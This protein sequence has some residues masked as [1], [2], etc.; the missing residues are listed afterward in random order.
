MA[1]CGSAVGP[2]ALMRHRHI[3]WNLAG[4]GLPLLVAL[5]AV[6]RLLELLGAQRFGLLALAWGLIGYASA[7]DLGIG[8]ATTQAVAAMRG[9]RADSGI[10][11]VVHSALR[12]TICSGAVAML[13]IA[14]AALAGVQSSIEAAGV[15]A[16]EMQRSLLLLAFALPLQAIA[17]TYRGVNEAFLNFAG[18]NLLRMLLG[19]AN[20]AAPWLIA[21]WTVELHWLVAT[22][23]LSRALA[24]VFYRSQARQ[25]LRREGHGAGRYRRDVAR[26]L[27]GFGAGFTVS[28]IVG[29]L[30][31]QSD[32]FFVGALLGAAAVTTYVIPY[33]VVVQALIGVG[34]VA[35]VIFPVVSSLLRADPPAAAALFRLWRTRVTV[36]MTLLMAGLAA[37]LPA[38]LGW[39]LHA[40]PS[41]D[42]IAIGRILCV[43]VVF[44]SV[45][46]MYFSLLHARGLTRATAVLHLAELPVYFLL[47]FGLL[48]GVGVV[49]CALAWTLRTMVDALLLI[50]IS[51]SASARS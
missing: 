9:G 39:W 12:L 31:V 36:A 19:A 24:L 45:G 42:S 5:I 7:L 33:E 29:P 50:A 48:Q 1:G 38:L 17:A 34:A 8:R 22:L 51:R 47:L 15:P 46:T 14:L 23:V 6:P 37:L 49:G 32:R 28:G 26:R 27:L 41:V 16:R 20:F 21:R 30:M 43:G 40:E 3:L 25:C 44:N 2:P 11:D 18:I 10:A 35:S 4:L 13:A